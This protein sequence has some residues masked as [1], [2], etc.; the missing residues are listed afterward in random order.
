MSKGFIVLCE[1]VLWPIGEVVSIPH[2]GY[3]SRSI[4]RL[5]NNQTS[6]PFYVSGTRADRSKCIAMENLGKGMPT[7]GC[8]CHVS[9]AF[10]E[11]QELDA[12]ESQIRQ[13]HDTWR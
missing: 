8:P 10:H 6:T 7:L 4:P 2:V 9:L 12:S 1:L 3:V 11:S 5:V 13:L